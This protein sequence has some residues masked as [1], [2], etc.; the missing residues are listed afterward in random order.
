MQLVPF[1]PALEKEITNYFKTVTIGN[2]SSELIFIGTLNKET[3]DHYIV[4][5]ADISNDTIVYI[6][7][8][9]NSRES[10]KLWRSIRELEQVRVTID[11]FYGGLVFF[12]REQ[13]K[14]HFK[15]RI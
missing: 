7:K 3:I 4:Q 13:V 10:Y 9:H 2:S 8:I 5:N 11:L 14:E 12:R 15:I 1:E 6:D